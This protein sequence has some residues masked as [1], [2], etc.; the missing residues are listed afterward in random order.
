MIVRGHQHSLF[1]KFTNDSTDAV[2]YTI[3][4]AANT[5]DTDAT[6]ATIQMENL[7]WG[8][9]TYADGY[10]LTVDPSESVCM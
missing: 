1:Y 10:V 8:Y 9:R 5:Q 6:P 2:D 7:Q 4:V 3:N